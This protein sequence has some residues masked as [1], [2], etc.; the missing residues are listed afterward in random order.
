M[1]RKK[2]FNAKCFISLE[3][4]LCEKNQCIY[5]NQ[6]LDNRRN[7]LEVT[8]PDIRHTARFVLAKIGMFARLTEALTN[9]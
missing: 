4:C 8:H 3:D 1:K 7:C 5:N 2:T 9:F 6:V